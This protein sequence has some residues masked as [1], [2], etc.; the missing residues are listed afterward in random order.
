MTI[1]M[2]EAVIEA[3]VPGGGQSWDDTAKRY[4]NNTLPQ[5]VVMTV[6]DS[7]GYFATKAL[8]E[9]AYGVGSVKRLSEKS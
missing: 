5:T 1:K 9:G 2:W 6:P 3:R 7:G 8:L 4:V